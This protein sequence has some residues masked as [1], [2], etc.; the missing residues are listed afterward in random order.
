LEIQRK[1]K[2]LKAKSVIHETFE[3]RGRDE[4]DETGRSDGCDE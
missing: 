3:K 2:K 4:I 1:A